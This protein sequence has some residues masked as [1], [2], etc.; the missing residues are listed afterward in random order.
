M[1]GTIDAGDITA[2]AGPAASSTSA[3]PITVAAVPLPRV[4]SVWQRIRNLYKTC[5]PKSVG[6]KSNLLRGRLRRAVGLQLPAGDYSCYKNS[7]NHR[8][9]LPHCGRAQASTQCSVADC[10]PCNLNGNYLDSTSATSRAT[11]CA[12]P[13]RPGHGQW[14]C[15]S[16]RLGLA[17]KAR[18]R[19]EYKRGLPHDLYP[20]PDWDAT[21]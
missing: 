16:T 15:A 9:D 17:R 19:L 1:G 12:Q 8:R 11:V 14:T 3:Q 2:T 18:L 7:H 4:A 21:V 13:R 6:F 5:G 20:G 10:V